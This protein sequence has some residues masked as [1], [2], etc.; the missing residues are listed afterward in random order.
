MTSENIT[1]QKA[2]PEDAQGIGEVYY[3]TWLATYPNEEYGVTKEDIDFIFKDIKN[4]DGSKYISLPD[5]TVYFTA[6]ENG[7]VVGVC[8]LVK[9]DDINELKSIYVLPEQQGKGVG[10][11]FW[12][13]ALK[14]FDSTKDTVVKAVVYNKNAIEFY[15]KLG[16]RETGKIFY[17]ETFRMQSGVI[18]PEIEMIIPATSTVV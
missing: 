11:M 16:F 15:K 9:H 5:N 6:K 8:K 18:P 17:D 14:F 1:I 2:I 4:S 7:H 12:S 10:K 3:K 13:E